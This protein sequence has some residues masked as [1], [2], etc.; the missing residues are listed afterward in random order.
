MS[1]DAPPL[2]PALSPEYEGEGGALSHPN[3]P[4]GANK[5]V[6]RITINHAVIVTD[7]TTVVQKT[8][9]AVN[10]ASPPI[11]SVTSS[12]FTAVGTPAVRTR[13]SAG[14]GQRSATFERPLNSR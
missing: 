6:D 13:F 5:V 10:S 7:E 12:V 2:T 9:S 4:P 14:H 8:Q 11:S 1:T 3:N